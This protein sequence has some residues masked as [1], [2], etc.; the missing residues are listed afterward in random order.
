MLGS[1]VLV[2]NFIFVFVT[3]DMGII[4]PNKEVII[5]IDQIKM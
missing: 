5:A 2:G 3:K 4:L 1:E